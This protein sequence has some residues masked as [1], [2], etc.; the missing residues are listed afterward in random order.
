MRQL[1][2]ETRCATTDV[3]QSPDLGVRCSH[4][5]YYYGFVSI[6]NSQLGRLRFRQP[7]ATAIVV[8]AVD[9]RGPEG[10][11]RCATRET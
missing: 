4:S 11:R 9:I 2:N 1:R 3:V 7:R 10:L 8:E 6:E 5:N